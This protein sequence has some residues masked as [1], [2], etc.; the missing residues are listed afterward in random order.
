MYLSGLLQQQY[1]LITRSLDADDFIRLLH[2][3]PNSTVTEDTGQAA[4]SAA[5]QAIIDQVEADHK[6]DEK[7]DLE[8]LR[9]L[10]IQQPDKVLTYV[11]NTTD[12]HR[13]KQRITE[14][15]PHKA[16]DLTLEEKVLIDR[17]WKRCETAARRYLELTGRYFA[18]AA[19]DRIVEL[20]LLKSGYK[21]GQERRRINSLENIARAEAGQDV[22]GAAM[23]DA[24]GAEKLRTL[25]A[26]Q[27]LIRWAQ[28][29][30]GK[31]HT[32]DELWHQAKTCAW[33]TALHLNKKTLTEEIG[34]LFDLRRRKSGDRRFIV[35]GHRLS[36]DEV[37]G[38]SKPSILYREESSLV[39]PTLTN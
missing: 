33:Y 20:C 7:S 27:Q 39:C 28:E 3:V 35:I 29:R 9:G 30:E 22:E 13:L 15:L 23:Q 32:A 37:L 1:D 38:H 17:R 21:Y 6:Q 26:H 2:G 36:L 4:I 11:Y 34:L 16:D 18:T 5:E 12:D 8:A 19:M 25:R 31:Q 14:R 10:M 24:T